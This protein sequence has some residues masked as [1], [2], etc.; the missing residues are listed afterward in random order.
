MSVKRSP[1]IRNFN[2]TRHVEFE[3]SEMRH[4]ALATRDRNGTLTRGRTEVNNE[5]ILYFIF[6]IAAEH[7]KKQFSCPFKKYWEGTFGKLKSFILMGKSI[8]RPGDARE[9]P[10][11][12][13]PLSSQS[14][15]GTCDRLTLFLLCVQEKLKMCLLH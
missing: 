3:R 14:M 4:E 10:A 11:S 2:L 12:P 8:A 5:Y 7:A 15:W 6:F 1:M 13:P 9:A